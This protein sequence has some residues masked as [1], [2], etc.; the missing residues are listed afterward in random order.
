MLSEL[1]LSVGD[2]ILELVNCLLLLLDDRGHSQPRCL[3]LLS[4]QLE[5]LVELVLQLIVLVLVV[6]P[7][8]LGLFKCGGFFFHLVLQ[9]LK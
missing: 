4:L 6:D 2:L 8:P 1:D 5:L 7:F 9:I 3:E